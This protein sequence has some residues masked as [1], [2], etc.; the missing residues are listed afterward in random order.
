MTPRFGRNS[1]RSPAVPY[2]DPESRTSPS[3]EELRAAREAELGAA[4]GE[5]EA[6]LLALFDCLP[7]WNTV[8][9]GKARH[10]YWNGQN[11]FEFDL[12]NPP[13]WVV[14]NI[15]PENLPPPTLTSIL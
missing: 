3:R 10:H 12:N 2:T 14:E 8:E 4:A 5:H 1:Y 7:K 13:L 11:W 6:E 9:N 15:D